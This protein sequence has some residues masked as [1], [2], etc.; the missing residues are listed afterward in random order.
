MGLLTFLSACFLGGQVAKEKLEKPIPAEYWRNK[1]LMNKDKLNPN[2]SHQQVMQ[3]LRNG[4][5]YLPYDPDVLPPHLTGK[6]WTKIS[7]NNRIMATKLPDE[8]WKE[9]YKRE[10]MA[11]EWNKNLY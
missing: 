8:T 4:K 6:G 3:N 10:E 9:Y 5:Y 2:I 1:Q 11:K 7:G